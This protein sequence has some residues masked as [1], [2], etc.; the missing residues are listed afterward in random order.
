MRARFTAALV[1]GIS[2]LSPS[3]VRAGLY[4][5][6]EPMEEGMVIAENGAKAL[7]F[8]Q[9]EDVLSTLIGIGVE[10][11][12]GSTQP[13][14]PKRKHYLAWKDELQAKA[15]TGRITVPE[16]VN[17]SAYLIRLRQYEEAVQVLEPV[18]A[19]ERENFMLFAN[20]ATAHQLAGR[21]ER[22]LGYLQQVKLLWPPAWPGLT[23]EQLEWFRTAEKYHLKLLTLRSR[24][25]AGSTG[26]RALAHEKLDDLFQGEHGP[27]RFAAESGRYEAGKLAAAERAKLPAEALAVVQQLV[28]WLPEDT[29]LYWLL[30]ELYNAHGDLHAAAKIFDECVGNVRRFSAP[31]LRAHRLVVQE[32]KPKSSSA[33]LDAAA[34]RA[35]TP[36]ESAPATASPPSWLPDSRQLVA[37]GTIAALVVVLMGYFQIREM[38]RRRGSV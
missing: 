32:A 5:T 17:L 2:L 19:Q 4:N 36:A 29:R 38:R 13:A 18:A 33:L 3:L 20:L 25:L 15:R 14:S 9:F 6:A 8:S 30:G 1:L 24:E 27:I 28:L 12:F 21:P 34:D 31:A 7:G 35:G 22:A 37:V 26:G 16:R 11:P 23:R 10:P